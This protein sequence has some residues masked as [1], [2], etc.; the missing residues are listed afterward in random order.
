MKGGGDRRTRLTAVPVI[1]PKV[2]AVFVD[3]RVEQ[4][5]VIERHSAYL[6]ISFSPSIDLHG[7]H[8]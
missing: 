2:E 6:F 7:T 3:A 8:Y 4:P 1:R 5:E